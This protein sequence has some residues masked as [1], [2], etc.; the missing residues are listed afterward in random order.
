MRWIMDFM[1]V[2]AGIYL[3]KRELIVTH[4]LPML[5]NYTLESIYLK[6]L[7]RNGK[8]TLP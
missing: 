6:P 1:Q 2:D 8:G 4:I 7:K 5:S 3:R